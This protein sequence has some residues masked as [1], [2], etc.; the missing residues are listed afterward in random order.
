MPVQ[1]PAIG[2]RETYDTADFGQLINTLRRRARTILLFT[3]LAG[4]AALLHALFATPQFTAQGALY[5][6]DTQQS[7]PST[8]NDDG[9]VNLF[10]YSTQSDV[11]T[12]IEL[13]TTGTL[14]E[15]AVLETGLNTT[16]RPTGKPPL[17]YW[18]WRLF[19]GG[20][21]S[22]FLP[23]PQSLQVVNATLAGR[24]RLE[25][26]PDNSYTLYTVGDLF[27]TSKPV[28]T[29][30]IGQMAR[31]P[32]GTLLVRFAQPDEDRAAPSDLEMPASN[33]AEATPGVSYSLSIVPPNALAKN[34][35]NG[36]LSVN[37]GGPPTQPTKL[38]T[39][40]F[41]WS[42]PYQAKLFINQMMQDYIATQLQWKTE[43]AS[44]TES[45]VTNQL[46]KVSQQLKDADRSLSDY[47]AQTGIIDPE[48]S[49]QAEATQMTELQRQRAALLLKMQALQQ[50]HAMLNAKDI[51]VNE[52]LISQ[53]DD[54]V[55]SEFSTS[56]SQ[57]EV[58]LSQL[59]AEYTHNAQDVK[60]QQAQVTQ[61]RTSIR[62][63]IENDMNA[64]TQNLADI[65]KLISSYR[66]DL[67]S[68]PAESLKVESLKRTSDQLGKLYELLIQKAEQAQ[69]SEVATIIDTRI[70]TPSQ[71]PLG[72]TSPRLLITVVAGALAGFIS[73]VALVFAQH[74][75]SGRYESEEQIRRTIALPVYGAVPRQDLT[76]PDNIAR[77]SLPAPGPF[78]AFSEA[79]QL[80]KRNIYRHTDP[81]HINTILVISANPQDGKTTIAANLA[82]SLADDGKRVL[83]L[84]CD[85]YASR[86]QGLAVFAGQPGLTDWVRTGKRPLL[87]RWPGENFHVLPAGNA[88][89]E[90]GKRPDEPAL[91]RI[92][93]SLRSDFDYLILDSPP[94]PIV[95]D[96]LLLGAFA[97]LILSVIN[98]SHTMRRAFELHM[99]LI[100][101]LDKP[102]A[103]VINGADVA[104][105]GDSH[106][107][108]LGTARRRPLF[109][110]W[111]RIN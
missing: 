24:Y 19:D 88:W 52:Y 106:T 95:S 67:K 21:T 60:I 71:L 61:L 33:P 56:L 44:V 53:A 20:N 38:A 86:L 3:T 47:Q 108:F 41:R 75:F 26:G 23:G 32:A 91:A 79:F 4:T 63:L 77:P 72:T 89:P 102:H 30:T 51:T 74:G 84:N 70:V 82:K 1:L 68:Q 9:T 76:A 103:L 39:L 80:I 90:H 12:Q 99:E 57:A 101:T 78:D 17:T 5:L 35:T 110:N 65:D 27:R 42:D 100:E 109:T 107:Y 64:A 92:I 7:G 46:S 83:L 28:L 62:S 50:L 105:Y 54:T 59:E 66:D 37:A 18:R 94:L 40:E 22:F 58:K 85:I 73:G 13:L 49:A 29:G 16:L 45:F 11:E 10:A 34:L 104:S 93:E 81:H 31:S 25:I 55:L 8:G 87:Q 14:I 2:L 43:A 111:F 48:Q 36:A 69:I 98:V 15:R 97:D 6:G 96:G